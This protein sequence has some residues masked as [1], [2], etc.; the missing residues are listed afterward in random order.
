M[1]HFDISA[2]QYFIYSKCQLSFHETKN[3]DVTADVCLKVQIPQAT[4]AKNIWD[5]VFKN[6]P[7]KICGGQPLKN[8]KSYDLYMQAKFEAI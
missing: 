8:F 3:I 1:V 5:K 4:I 2:H 6:G 7:N